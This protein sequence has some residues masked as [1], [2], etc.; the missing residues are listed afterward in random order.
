MSSPQVIDLD[1]MNP[2][3]LE[4]LHQGMVSELEALTSNLGTLKLAY[5]K[6]KQS[7]DAVE[8]LK[9]AENGCTCSNF[10]LSLMLRSC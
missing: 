9:S 8:S 5:N 3:D 6:Y 2:R 1:A 4:S 10:E 7:Y